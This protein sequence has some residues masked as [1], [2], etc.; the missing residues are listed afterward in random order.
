MITQTAIE[1]DSYVTFNKNNQ[2]ANHKIKLIK[3]A[4]SH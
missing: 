4:K 3:S 2:S 1:N